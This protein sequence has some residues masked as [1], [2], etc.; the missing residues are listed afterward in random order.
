MKNFALALLFSATTLSFAQAQSLNN[1]NWDESKRM[2]FLENRETESAWDL[3]MM[4][5]DRPIIEM[6]LD[7]GPF[8]YGVFPVPKYELTVGDAN[9]AVGNTPGSY[10]VN[11]K[12]IYMNSFQVYSN[13]V[14]EAMLNGEESRSFFQIAIQTEST[15][16]D[17]QFAILSRNHPD[18]MGQGYL[19][20]EQG[21]IDYA[22]F[23][24]AEGESFAIVNSRLFNLKYGTMILIAPQEDGTLRSKQIKTPGLTADEVKDFTQKTLSKSEAT[25]FFN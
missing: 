1:T 18:Y 10:E 17:G 16:E 22:A 9:V 19:N 4:E 14:N 24:T 13:P 6:G 21:R 7:F 8:P 2:E 11:G 25:K 5:E 15:E 12:S 3:D 23:I 20:T